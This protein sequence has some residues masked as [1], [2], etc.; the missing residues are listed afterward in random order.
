MR[1]QYSSSEQGS[2]DSGI[3]SPHHS[4]LESQ[5]TTGGGGGA[6]ADG[7]LDSPVPPHPAI[8]TTMLASK[9]KFLVNFVFYPLKRAL[10]SF[11]SV[12]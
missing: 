1:G 3:F 7:E 2:A 8:T 9:E 6:G 10:I 12:S 4:E 11:L 5:L